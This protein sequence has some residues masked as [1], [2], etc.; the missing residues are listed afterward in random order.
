MTNSPVRNMDFLRKRLTNKIQ[1]SRKT[2]VLTLLLSSLVFVLFFHCKK[3]T[4]QSVSGTSDPVNEHLRELEMTHLQIQEDED[5]GHLDGILHK[6]FPAGLAHLTREE[7]SVKILR[8]TASTIALKDEEPVSATRILKRGSGLC[9]SMAQVFVI[10]CRRAGIPARIISLHHMPFMGGHSVSEVFYNG[11]WHFFDPTFGIFFYNRTEY[12]GKG[13][14]ASF[15]DL[16]SNMSRWIPFKVLDRP[17][18]GEYDEKVIRFGIKRVERN[19]MEYKYG[20]PVIEIFKRD[21]PAAR[22]IINETGSYYLEID[23]EKEGN[24][25]LGTI[26]N[27]GNDLS[28][29]SSDFLGANYLGYGFPPRS[30]IF[31]IKTSPNSKVNIEYFWV[32]GYFSTPTLLPLKN[33]ELI[34]SR[35]EK[36]KAFFTVRVVAHEG[37]VKIVNQWPVHR[38]FDVDAIHFSIERQS[39]HTLFSLLSK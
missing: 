6:I 26:N 29:Y 4:G 31:R 34:Q 35:Y 22:P 13:N 16:A 11:K 19:Y 27:D 15:C 1:I 21:F 39:S 33:A 10:L 2:V 25:W 36:G 8:Y 32:A 30:H 28:L 20:I 14:I 12:D 3:E 18:T 5:L 7:R 23:L 38:V 9:S 17:W 24:L 37:I